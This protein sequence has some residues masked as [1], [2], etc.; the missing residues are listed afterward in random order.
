MLSNFGT[1]INKCEFEGRS[2]ESAAKSIHGCY[3]IEPEHFLYEIFKIKEKYK[4]SEKGD[5]CDDTTR[6]GNRGHEQELRAL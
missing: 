2:S 3:V 1:V 5:R 6:L 4:V